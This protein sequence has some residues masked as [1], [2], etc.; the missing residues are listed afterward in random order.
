[1]RCIVLQ[2]RGCNWQLL[3]GGKT[4]GLRCSADADSENYNKCSRGAD[5]GQ[6]LLMRCGQ[7]TQIFCL[8]HLYCRPCENFR[9]VIFHMP[10]K[11]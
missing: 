1:M 8:R 10:V 7:R 2:V 6:K 3:L 9:A 4:L 5:N 11:T